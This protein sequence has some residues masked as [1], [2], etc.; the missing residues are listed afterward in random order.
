MKKQLFIRQSAILFLLVALFISPRLTAQQHQLQG[1]VADAKT[2]EPLAFVNILINDGKYGGTTDIDGKFAITS[3]EPIRKLKF[4]FIGYE[5]YEYQ[6]TDDKTKLKIRLQ[7]ID[8]ELAEI[9]IRPGINPAHRIIDSVLLY[10]DRNHPNKM[11]SYAYTAYDKLVLTIDTL[12]PIAKKFPD[13]ILVDTVETARDFLRQRDMF[14]METVTEKKF[15]APDRSHEKILATKISGLKDPIFVFLISRTQSSNFYDETIQVGD[16]NYIN[17]ISKGSNKKYLFILEESTA[18]GENDSLFSISFRPLLNTNFDG[19]QGMINIHSDGWAIQNVSAQPYRDE[20]GFSI[21]IQQMYEKIDGERWF[22][23]Q[24]NTDL[25]FKGAVI[26]DGVN[27]YPMV[28][29]GKSYFKDIV[30]N[31]ELMRRQFSNIAVEVSPDAADKD[32]NFWLQHRIDSL[33]ERTL[34]TY[35]YMDSLGKA[36]NFDRYAKS[37]ETLQTGRIP[38][39]MFDLR[40]DKLL[41]YNAYEGLYLGL[42]LQTNDKFSQAVK[43]GGFWGYGFGDETAKYGLDMQLQIDRYKEISLEAAYSYQA[44]ETGGFTRFGEAPFALNQSNFRDFFINRMD[45]TTTIMG[46]V[47]FRALRH[48]KWKALIEVQE[49]TNISEYAFAEARQA[50][51]STF[52]FTKIQLQ[53]RFAFKEKFMQTTRSLISLGSAYPTVWLAYTKSFDDLLDGNYAFDKWEFKTSYSW[54]TPYFGKTDITLIAGLVE[55]NTPGTELF[56]TSGTYREFTLYA[57]E[58]FGTMRTNE[59]LSDRFTALFF[60]HNF[61]KLLF[62]KGKFEPEF[63][64]ATNIAFGQLDKP[65]LHQGITFNTLEHGF[66]ESGLMINN[67]L[68]LTGLRLGVGAFYR[69][70]PYGFDREWKNFGYKFGM[71]YGF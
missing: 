41:R 28:G 70:G 65:L 6:I 60:S 7:P 55:G 51:Q 67:L 2:G 15:L 3:Q 63:V 36:H 47:S 40:I 39:K 35:R 68:K 42:G 23:V 46:G 49:K 24:L 62:R 16:K 20:S 29:I 64:L 31:P 32:V 22:P 1:N 4:S 38:I 50:P 21:R 54:F 66:Y 34:E 45:M 19:L 44:L 53:T 33:T 71:V 8:F 61:G 48:F 13:T 27:Q 18:I 59:F 17:P 58:S 14:M 26:D 5:A 37:L 56:N 12:Y 9:V 69:F 57:P 52:K 43:L 10:R 11:A 25:L 30:L